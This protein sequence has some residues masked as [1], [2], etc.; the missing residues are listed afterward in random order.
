MV[1]K[2]PQ[3]KAKL[4]FVIDLEKNIVDSDKLI[5]DAISKTELIKISKNQENL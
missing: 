2:H 5:F 1:D 3:T 4:D